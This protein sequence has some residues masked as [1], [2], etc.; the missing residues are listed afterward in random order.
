[1]CK[2]HLLIENVFDFFQLRRAE[3]G[4]FQV[5]LSLGRVGRVLVDGHVILA[6]G[7]RRVV[8]L[9]LHDDDDQGCGNWGRGGAH[10]LGVLFRKTQRENTR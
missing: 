2:C 5:H 4:K 3:L 8:L 7:I 6:A 10:V 9:L 1:M